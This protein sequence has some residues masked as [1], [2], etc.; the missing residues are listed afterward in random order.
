M[1]YFDQPD[2]EGHHHGP[3]SVQV[4][5]AVQR[6]DAIVGLFLDGLEKHNLN[7]RVR[8]SVRSGGFTFLSFTVNW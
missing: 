4:A 3:D 5:E 6:M 1:V 2:K 8:I 7:D